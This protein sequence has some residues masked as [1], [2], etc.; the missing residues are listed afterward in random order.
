L[1]FDGAAEGA[2]NIGQRS[3]PTLQILWPGVFQAIQ[4]ADPL[5][6]LGSNC[7]LSLLDETGVSGLDLRLNG[8]IDSFEGKH[9]ICVAHHLRVNVPLTDG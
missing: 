5:V 9:N 7:G 6:V 3:P 2:E 1:L 8:G 4:A